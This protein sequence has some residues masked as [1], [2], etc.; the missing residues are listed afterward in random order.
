MLTGGS[1]LFLPCKQVAYLLGGE[2]HG[3]TSHKTASDGQKTLDFEFTPTHNGEA[4]LSD[5]RSLPPMLDT[6]NSIE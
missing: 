2:E 1:P 3:W 4:T 5:R 6:N